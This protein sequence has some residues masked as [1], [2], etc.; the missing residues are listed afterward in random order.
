[1]CSISSLSAY[2]W[3]SIFQKHPVKESF[4]ILHQFWSM[5]S[6]TNLIKLLFNQ[7]LLLP[8]IFG[9]TIVKQKSLVELIIYNTHC[10][11]HHTPTNQVKKCCLIPTDITQIIYSISSSTNWKVEILEKFSKYIGS[12]SSPFFFQLKILKE[13]KIL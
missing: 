13:N 4:I 9:T 5:L 8:F 3:L 6:A 7:V 10:A 2:Q 11:F 12:C 1:M